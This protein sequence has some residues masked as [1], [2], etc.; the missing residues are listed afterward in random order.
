MRWTIQERL[1]GN[2]LK[3]RVGINFLIFVSQVNSKK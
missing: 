1:A 2:V 3:I